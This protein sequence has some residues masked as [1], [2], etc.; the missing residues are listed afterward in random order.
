MGDM[1]GKTSKPNKYRIKH[2]PTKAL[3]YIS[4]NTIALTAC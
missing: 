3:Q 1:L 2:Q 4:S